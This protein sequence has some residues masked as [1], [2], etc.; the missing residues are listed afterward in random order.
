MVCTWRKPWNH[1]IFEIPRPHLDEAV[2]M[3]H[4]AEV[5]WKPVEAVGDRPYEKRQKREVREGQLVGVATVRNVAKD[6]EPI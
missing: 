2:K 1:N 4:R 5:L 3:E 6:L